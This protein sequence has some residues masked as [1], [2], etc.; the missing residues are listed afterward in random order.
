MLA[1]KT[2]FNFSQTLGRRM[3]GLSWV[4]DN[5][6]CGIERSKKNESKLGENAELSEIAEFVFFVLKPQS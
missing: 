6:K 2:I 3:H 4:A 5:L 1:E